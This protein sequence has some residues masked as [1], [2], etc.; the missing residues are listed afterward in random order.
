MTTAF[1]GTAFPLD[2]KPDWRMPSQLGMGP[3]M[4]PDPYTLG[5][6]WVKRHREGPCV[7]YITVDEVSPQILV[8]DELLR[9][10]HYETAQFQT[11]AWVELEDPEYDAHADNPECPGC[12]LV[13][14]STPDPRAVCFT[15]M[16]LHVNARNRKLIYQIGQYRPQSRTWEAAW[17]D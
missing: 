5:D 9:A 15:G 7:E 3:G 1:E 4:N 2:L 12:E 8:G 10:L 6:L 11:C 16:M 17:P 13:A 14:E